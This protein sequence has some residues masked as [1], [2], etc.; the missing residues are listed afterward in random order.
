MARLHSR[1]GSMDFLRIDGDFARAVLTQA[2]GTLLAA[3]VILLVGLA[4][5]VVSHIDLRTA[6]SVA[7]AMLAMAAGLLSVSRHQRALEDLRQSEA[8]RTLEG[9]TEDERVMLGK[10]FDKGKWNNMSE[11]EQVEVFRAMRNAIDRRS[12]KDSAGD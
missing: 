12:R 8:M 3:L 6:L 5:G 7:G 10:Y 9:M 2:L 4:A 11:A 1:A